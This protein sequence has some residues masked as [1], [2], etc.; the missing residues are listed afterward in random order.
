MRIVLYSDCSLHHLR[1]MQSYKP[2]GLLEK[3][4][5]QC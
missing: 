1:Y 2:S 3:L 5:L 4:Y